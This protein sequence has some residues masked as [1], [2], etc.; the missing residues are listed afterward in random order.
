MRRMHT[1]PAQSPNC[2]NQYVLQIDGSGDTLVLFCGRLL[3]EGTGWWW[4]LATKSGQVRSMLGPRPVSIDDPVVKNERRTKTKMLYLE[5]RQVGCWGELLH[6]WGMTT[7]VPRR[8][9]KGQCMAG[10]CAWLSNT[11][12]FGMHGMGRHPASRVSMTKGV[13]WRVW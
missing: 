5:R 6:G 9:A 7:A 12:L 13:V 4:I 2:R 3:A 10:W 8:P 1:S 11:S